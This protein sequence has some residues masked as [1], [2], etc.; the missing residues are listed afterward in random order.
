MKVC[1][2]AQAEA[3]VGK[4][5]NSSCGDGHQ[6]AA[7]GLVASLSAMTPEDMEVSRLLSLWWW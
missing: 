3:G 7:A 1:G 2:E 6:G 5:A 4:G